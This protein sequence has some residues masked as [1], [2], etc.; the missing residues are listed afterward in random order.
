LLDPFV[1]YQPGHAGA[2]AATGQRMA[3][4]SKLKAE[5]QQRESSSR[6]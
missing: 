2:E 6:D 5:I 3:Q 1:C 4:L